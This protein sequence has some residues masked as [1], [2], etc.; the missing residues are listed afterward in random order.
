[1]FEYGRSESGLPRGTATAKDLMKSL[2]IELRAGVG[3]A[4]E[5]KAQALLETSAAVIDGLIKAFD[6]YERRS[7]AEQ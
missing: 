4:E 5:P 7:E 1:L 6:D 3:E 2:V